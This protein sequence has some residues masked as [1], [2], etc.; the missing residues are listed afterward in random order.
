MAT[1]RTGLPTRQRLVFVPLDDVTVGPDYVR[2][3]YDRGMVRKAPAIGTDGV[4][5]AED[6]Q[7]VFDHYGMAYRPGAAGERRLARR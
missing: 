2:V 1:V 3:P 5:A 6:E 7:A 4:L